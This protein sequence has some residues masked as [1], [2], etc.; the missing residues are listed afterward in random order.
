MRNSEWTSSDFLP[1]CKQQITAILI[2]F[3]Q[4]SKQAPW[5]IQYCW[6]L[7]ID[8]FDY[9]NILDSNKKYSKNFQDLH[10]MYVYWL[11]NIGKGAKVALKKNNINIAP[12]G[13]D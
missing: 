9:R 5:N 8:S 12:K 3:I 10:S 4:D 11:L 6:L 13:D 1:Y 7:L 2:N